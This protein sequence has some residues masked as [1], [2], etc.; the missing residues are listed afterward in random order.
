[1]RSA[2]YSLASA[3]AALSWLRDLYSSSHFFQRLAFFPLARERVIL[4]A[5]LG[6]DPEIEL[7]SADQA[8]IGEAAADY[9]GGSVSNAGDVN[10][11]GLD[12]ILIEAHRND[13]GGSNAGKAY[14]LLAPTTA[15]T[16]IP[17]V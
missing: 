16:R 11:D 12:D 17:R 14:L 1:M 13:D 8:F 4:A 10:G 5:S 9:A 3:E 7:S 6:G 2:V 15:A